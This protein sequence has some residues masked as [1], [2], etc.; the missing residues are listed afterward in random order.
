M[1]SGGVRV[2]I[3]VSAE[4]AG[5]RLDR[6]LTTRVADL[7]R[8]R[9]KALIE[10]GQ[11]SVGGAVLRDPAYHVKAA[12]TVV[13]D[14]PEAA[15]AEPAAEDIPLDVVFE[16]DAIIVINKPAG[17]V[18]HPAAGHASG[19]LV[20]ALIAHCGASLS[21]IGGVKRPGIVHRL[22]K[23]TT[24]ILIAA[25]TD[26][27]HQSLTRQFADHGRTGELRRAYVALAWGAPKLPSGTIDLPIDRHRTVREK[28]AVRKEGREA[29]THWQVIE[30]FGGQEGEAVASA[31][32]CELETGR[33]HQ[34][35]VHLAHAGHPLLGD[36]VYGAGFKTKASRLNAEARELLDSLRRQALHAAHLTIEHPVT[37]EVMSFDAAWP[38]DMAKLAQALRHARA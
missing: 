29:I 18:V 7:S 36:E 32:A 26:A 34:I 28:M 19:T 37:G 9:L 25:K 16:D 31:L 33:T 20:N 22:D 11:V 24:G 8:S 4:E 15:P 14:V 6:M 38:D 27:A 13:V 21:G 1:M 5:Q 23:D 17:L 35:R 10:Q 12:E 3:A 30:R 2:E